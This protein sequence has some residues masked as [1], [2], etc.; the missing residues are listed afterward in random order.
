M[1]GTFFA[2]WAIVYILGMFR[3]QYIRNYKSS[4]TWTTFFFVNC[5]FDNF[6]K[7]W[8]FSQTHLVTLNWPKNFNRKQAVTVTSQYVSINMCRHVGTNKTIHV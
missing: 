3:L 5:F 6:D 8:V 1:I 7:K 2:F 4:L